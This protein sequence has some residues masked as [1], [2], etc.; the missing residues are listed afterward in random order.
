MHCNCE[1]D[2]F[3]KFRNIEGNFKETLVNDVQGMLS[4]Y[5]ASHLRVR[6]EDLLDEA[7][8]FTTTHLGL[9]QSQVNPW[10]AGQVAQ[11]LK[12]PMRKCFSRILARHFISIYQDD[13]SRSEILLNFAKLDFNML[14]KMHKRELSELTR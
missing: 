13:D 11:A 14:Q 2:V 10:L 3:N 8:N 6:G 5:E 1:T 9:K 12:Q 7:L 4:L